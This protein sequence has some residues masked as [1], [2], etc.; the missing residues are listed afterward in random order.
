MY[1]IFAQENVDFVFKAD[2]FLQKQLAYLCTVSLLKNMF[3]AMINI[4]QGR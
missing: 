2:D 1:G 3:S 4:V